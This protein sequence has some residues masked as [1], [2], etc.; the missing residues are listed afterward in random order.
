MQAT[1]I[2]YVNIVMSCFLHFSESPLKIMHLGP[3]TEINGF[4]TPITKLIS[5]YKP[6]YTN[7]W[8]QPL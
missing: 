7:W 4:I 6:T 5:H 3:L 8:F 2:I 1:Q